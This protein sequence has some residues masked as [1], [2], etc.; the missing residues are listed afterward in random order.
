MNRKETRT[1]RHNERIYK[2][3]SVRTEEA[4]E[5]TMQ[6]VRRKIAT[7]LPLCKA[8]SQTAKGVMEETATSSVKLILCRWLQVQLAENDE[9]RRPRVFDE[10]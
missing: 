7:V 6:S 1:S 8:S 2:S 5:E 4:Q 3:G 9:F 10:A